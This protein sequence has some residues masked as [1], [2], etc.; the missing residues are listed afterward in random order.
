MQSACPACAARASKL[1]H[2]PPAPRHR[3]SGPAARPGEVPQPRPDRRGQAAGERCAH[4]RSRPCGSTPG[5][6]ATSP[7]PTATSSPPRTTTGW[8]ISSWPTRSLYDEIAV[9]GL[10][11]VEIGFTGGEPF[12][13]PDLPAMMAAAL[14]RGFSV[15]VLTNA[16]RPMQRPRV[17]AELHRAEG[18]PRPPPPAAG[19]P[20]SPRAGAARAASAGPAPGSRRSPGSTGWPANGFAIAVAGRTCWDE[21]A[22]AAR[23]GYA[24][25]SRRAAGRSMPQTPPPSCCSPRWTHASTCPR[26]PP[27]AGPSCTRARPT[28]CAPRAAWW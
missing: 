23:A 4:A 3:Q 7:A 5:R 17:K 19:E 16:M 1:R 6:C 18:A 15:L 26:S 12:M 28:S 21:P 11:T 2:D 13:N 27:P 20:R 10:G 8:P 24:R 25:C 9:L 14:E 22:A